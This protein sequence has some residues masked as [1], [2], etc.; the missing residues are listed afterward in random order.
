[1][2]E[3]EEGVKKIQQ[4]DGNTK[5]PKINLKDQ[6]KVVNKKTVTF[7]HMQHSILLM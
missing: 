7:K 2:T 6:T 3:R 4:C 1:M 5:S